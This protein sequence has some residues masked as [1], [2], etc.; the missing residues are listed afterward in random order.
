M[1]AHEPRDQYIAQGDPE[2]VGHTPKEQHV[3]SDEDNPLAGRET[4]TIFLKNFPRP[5]CKDTLACATEALA[6]GTT[7]RFGDL[8]AEAPSAITQIPSGM[9]SIQVLAPARAVTGA[10]GV[11]VSALADAAAGLPYLSTEAI[12]FRYIEPARRVLPV[13]GPIGGGTRVTVTA[14]GVPAIPA[15]ADVQVSILD[16]GGASL[17]SILDGGVEVLL[18]NAVESIAATE[19]SVVSRM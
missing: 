13:D 19:N 11:S 15:L 18:E 2:V 14:F 5:G 1:G 8:P 6:R 12:A 3:A 9:I 17:V 16:A 7:V 10:V 4:V